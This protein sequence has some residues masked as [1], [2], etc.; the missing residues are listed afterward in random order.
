[1]AATTTR[2]PRAAARPGSRVRA[3]LRGRLGGAPS[4]A[5]LLGL[6]LLVAVTYA[7]CAHG[8][9]G[10][11]EESR[12]QIGVVVLAFVALAAGLYGRV[13]RVDAPAGAKWGVALLAGF[14]AWAALSITWSVA[15]DE[16]WLEANRALAYALVAVLGMALGSSLPRA[17]ER[18]GVG[19]LAL[20]SL[21]ALYALGGKL[22]P[23][24][25]VAGL[26]DLNHTER[27]SRLRA[28]LD[29]WNALGLV[30]VIA[31]PLAMRVGAEPRYAARARLAG[32]ASLVLLLTTLALTYSRGG[33]L[34]LVAAVA[35]AIALGPDRLR[36]AALLGAGLLG[37]VVPV[38]VTLIRDDLTTDGLPI[39]QRSDDGLILLGALVLGLVIAL[40]LGRATVRAGERLALG[41]A[42]RRRARIGALVGAIAVV[43]LVLGGLALSERGIGG[44]ISHQAHEFAKPK[45]DR[46]NDPARVLR[47]NSGNRWVWWEEA[48]G[49]WSDRPLVGYG[50]G[51]F[52]ITHLAYRKNT[53]EVRQPHSVPLEFLTETGLVG[54]LLG[55]GGLALLGVA[56][57]R[58]VLA[59]PPGNERAFAAAL[60]AGAFA[61]TLHG[62]VDWDWDIPGVTLPALALLGVLV[63]RPPGPAT[64]ATADP[65]AAR[66]SRGLKLAAGGVM[67]CVAIAL[68]A[69]PA[70]AESLTDTALTR[71]ADNSA[72]GLRAGEEKAALAKRL[73]PFSVA[74][75][76]AQASIAERGNQPDAAAGLLVEAVDR[77][78]D[79][80]QT[81]TRL[82]RFQV[83]VN[84]SSAAL[85]SSY[86]LLALDPVAAFRTS[87]FVGGAVYDPAR[88]ASSTGTP[89]PEKVKAPPPPVASPAP[90]PPPGDQVPRRPGARDKTPTTPTTPPKPA[91][92]PTPAPRSAPA[93]KPKPRPTP[94]R[95]PSAPPGEPFRLEG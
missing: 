34:V 37:A 60:L 94:K 10:I 61:W 81:W 85:R 12:L 53:I 40:V 17:A 93:P 72:S 39:A 56:A 25:H 5:A 14:A 76:F 65:A 47:T 38:L 16:S 19:F 22:F 64:I 42:G 86:A 83:L 29:Y 78:P 84:D 66:G 32:V 48:V 4:S 52:P 45:L 51:S 87:G 26:I 23:W 50:A 79:N 1:M 89:L 91:P 33:L 6:G 7:A 59:R 57:T 8:A 13:L 11:P 69:L 62:W 75:V 30:C 9:I 2:R 77:Q 36:L 73:N 80:P 41:A 27:F 95:A 18:A 74:P 67:A 68:A 70:A 35:L 24:L 44:T 43:V 92:A 90:L 3:L 21:I 28:P 54:A 82:L 55:L 46:Q 71:A 63:A 88:S 15:P 31:V 58:G 49:G 20:A